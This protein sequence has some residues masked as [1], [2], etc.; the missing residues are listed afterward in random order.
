MPFLSSAWTSKRTRG[1]RKKENQSLPETCTLDEIQL[2]SGAPVNSR[3]HTERK[4]GA[5]VEAHLCRFVDS[6]I[7]G[8]ISDIVFSLWASVSLLLN[9]SLD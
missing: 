1:R 3:K 7:S 5:E 4:L 6:V 2:E 9:Q 8:K